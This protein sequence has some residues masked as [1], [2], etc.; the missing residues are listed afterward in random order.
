MGAG[1]FQGV[2]WINSGGSLWGSF[3]IDSGTGGSG[4]S[5]SSGS[6]GGFEEDLEQ[7][8][9][10]AEDAGDVVDTV[11]GWL[12]FDDE[13][14]YEQLKNGKPCAGGPSIQVIRN[15]LARTSAATRSRASQL[16]AEFSGDFPQNVPATDTLQLAR[17]LRAGYSGGFDCN[18]GGR[19][20][21]VRDFVDELLAKAGT[22]SGVD[23][24]EQPGANP[25]DP[26]G[27][28]VGDQ[29]LGLLEQIVRPNQ[30]KERAEGALTGARGGAEVGDNRMVL[31]LAFAVIVVLIVWGG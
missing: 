16:I 30:I 1:T 11:G 12:G 2:N 7:A 21:D 18:V 28:N 13:R 19:E 3:G 20:A 23:S 24:P 25:S 14:T 27:V 9:D 15:A 8:E 5:S 26:D 22:A 10:F 17:W 6:S 31:L 4:G 29:L